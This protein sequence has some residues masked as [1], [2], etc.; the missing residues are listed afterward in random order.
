MSC[1]SRNSG[2][3]GPKAEGLR[4]VYRYREIYINE[5]PTSLDIL[6]AVRV[7]RGHSVI[8]KKS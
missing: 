1:F 5:P 6:L 7:G 4:V 3:I 8:T 2:E